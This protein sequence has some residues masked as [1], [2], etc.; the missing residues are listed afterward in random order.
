MDEIVEIEEFEV[1]YSDA[2]I[3]CY[4]TCGG[5][6]GPFDGRGSSTEVIQQNILEGEALF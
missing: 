2:S 3:Q 1:V 4:C 5:P 6:R